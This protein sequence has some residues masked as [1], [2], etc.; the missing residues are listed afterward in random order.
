MTY[1][2]GIGIF[3]INDEGK[4]FIGQRFD[5]K[6]E[7]LQMPQGGI[8]ENENPEEALWREMMEEI[9]TNKASILHHIDEWLYY[10]L[11]SDIAQSIWNGRYI[12]QKQKWF[13]LSFDGKDNDI[14]INTENP[15]FVSWQWV[16]IDKVEDLAIDFKKDMY[17]TIVQHFK[18]IIL[19]HCNAS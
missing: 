11:P 13:L 8:D 18:P 15:E 4:V 10:D 1:R 2:A 16:N 6:T 17:K 19:S 14:N 12:G 7:A 3:L 5:E 9:G